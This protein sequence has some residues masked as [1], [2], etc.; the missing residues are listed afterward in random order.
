MNMTY[1]AIAKLK[2]KNLTHLRTGVMKCTTYSCE[3]ILSRRIET[4]SEIVSIMISEMFLHLRSEQC[5]Q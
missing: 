5:K 4:T 3:K 1:N 2:G